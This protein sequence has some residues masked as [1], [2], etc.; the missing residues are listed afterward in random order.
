[1]SLNKLK[2]IS[3]GRVAEAKNQKVLLEAADILV[4][5]KD[6]KNFEVDVIGAPILKPDFEYL[7]N[8]K[9]F[10][11]EK[12]LEEFIKFIG[13]VPHESIREYYEKADIFVHLSKTGSIDKVVLEALAIGVP[14]YSSSEAFKNILPP[15]FLIFDNPRE[16]AEKIANFTP[17]SDEA[18]SSLRD[19]VVENHSLDNLISKIVKE[20]NKG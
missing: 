12:K 4:N 1:M 5:Q 18:V 10:V 6:F 16:L 15:Q 7:K 14:V 19:Y 3:I 9:K 13:D 11:S 8:L 2:I 20:M 17:P